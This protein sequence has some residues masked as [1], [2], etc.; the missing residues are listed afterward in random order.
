MRRL[1]GRHM[2]LSAKVSG[3]TDKRAF[4]CWAGKSLASVLLAFIPAWGRGIPT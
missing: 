2:T 1:S 3:N 4:Y